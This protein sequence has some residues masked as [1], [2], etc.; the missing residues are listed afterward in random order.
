M[1]DLDLNS[2]CRQ[3]VEKT[4]D[5]V[6]FADRAG[7]IR[8]WNSGAERM[9][10]YS[11]QEAVG[12]SLDLII[13]EKNRRVHWDG[14]RKVM[15]TGITTYAEK[16]LAVPAIHRDGTRI[17]IEFSIALLRTPDGEP[18]GSAAIMR[19]VT[20]K[21]QK[22]QALKA[23]LAELESSSAPAAAGRIRD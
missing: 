14:Y 3:I 10:G 6:V 15:E 19:D 18:V 4:P 12:S 8:T 2:I 17:S 5:A 20:E 7:I 1:S 11:A 13:P 16:L 22:E 23:R 21:R 9:F